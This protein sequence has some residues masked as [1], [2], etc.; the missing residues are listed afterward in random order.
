[1]AFPA[2]PP[3]QPPAPTQGPVPLPPGADVWDAPV[4]PAD[5]WDPPVP[6]SDSW[7]PPSVPAEADLPSDTWDPPAPGTDTSPPSAP[8]HG[9]GPPTG[10]PAGAG[11]AHGFGPPSGPPAGAAPAWV[12]PPPKRSK[13]AWGPIAAGGLYVLFRI[14]VVVLNLTLQ[15]DDDR[16]SSA[17]MFPYDEVGQ[18]T[19]PDLE[20]T[21]DL[22]LPVAPGQCYDHRGDVIA[23][24]R[25][26]QGEAVTAITFSL[27]EGTRAEANT[28]CEEAVAADFGPTPNG[29]FVQAMTAPGT[30]DGDVHPVSCV[31]E[32]DP[33]GFPI[34]GH[35]RST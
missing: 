9:F 28:R 10:P 11:P 7:D 5:N 19:V 8:A 32:A 29:T 3:L 31:I 22:W 24:G 35:L 21:E 27:A 23:C 30:W 16:T 2:P 1:M 26:H 18:G 12:P 34:V 15:D 25:P 33:N 13:K 4:V 14:G 17:T 20:T 6:P